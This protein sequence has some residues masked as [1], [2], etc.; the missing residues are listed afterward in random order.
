M[1][2]DE[3]KTRASTRADFIAGDMDFPM[4]RLLLSADH[5]FWF[6]LLCIYMSGVSE[7]SFFYPH[8]VQWDY[9]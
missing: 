3:R 4:A 1:A 7:D 5:H 9:D 6:D 8:D 2:E